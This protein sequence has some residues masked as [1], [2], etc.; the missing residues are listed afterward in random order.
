MDISKTENQSLEKNDFQTEVMNQK[1]KKI[2]H[3]R[4]KNNYKNIKVLQSIHDDQQPIQEGFDMNALG[5]T[6]VPLSG[7]RPITDDMYE[8]E[9]KDDNNNG[10]MFEGLNIILEKSGDAIDSIYNFIYNGVFGN[11][12][13]SIYNSLK[14][15]NSNEL[16]EKNDTEIIKQ[17]II[18]F[19]CL[20]ITNRI[21]YRWYYLSIY[22][23]TNNNF[24]KDY[25]KESLESLQSHWFLKYVMLLFCG[26]TNILNIFNYII[27]FARLS[28]SQFANIEKDINNFVDNYKLS[29]FCII[30][31]LIFTGLFFL[32]R[33]FKNLWVNTVNF[34]LKNPYVLFI[35]ITLFLFITYN[36]FYSLI[37]HIYYYINPVNEFIDTKPKDIIQTAILQFVEN[38]TEIKNLGIFSIISK[39]FSPVIIVV[40]VII[41]IIILIIT[42]MIISIISYLNLFLFCFVFFCYFLY[43]SFFN[44][45]FFVEKYS[46]IEKGIDIK[47]DII[48]FIGNDFDPSKIFALFYSIIL[49]IFLFITGFS[50]KNEFVKYTFIAL[51]L[52]FC[53][54]FYGFGFDY[55]WESKIYNLFSSLT[56][57]EAK[58]ASQVVGE[59]APSVSSTSVS[60]PS[61]PSSP[62]YFKNFTDSLPNFTNLLP[63]FT[64]LL[65]K[66]LTTI[67]PK[68]LTTILPKDLTTILPK[69]FFEK[70]L[71]KTL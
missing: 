4:I 10:N 29:L 48:E 6:H 15:E 68:D 69:T 46:F 28:K 65:P 11:M 9:V 5:G 59:Q 43:N 57:Q 1:I 40:C 8:G 71:P 21:V 27:L 14:D 26:N 35:Y 12:A 45:T 30:Y 58:V 38:F 70:L 67:L 17:F 56:R 23:D 3:K 31:I 41:L 20:F 61:P 37:K 62:P 60:P 34:N 54:F 44:Y 39:L 66:D 64:N 19:V 47:Q 24:S 52:F 42:F 49:G 33:K 36:I 51:E 18:I 53:I 2:K 50:M 25:I 32:T 55:R 13:I 63:D 16:Q 22:H 7:V